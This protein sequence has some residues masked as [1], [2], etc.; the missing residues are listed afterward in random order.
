MSVPI[1]QPGV[2]TV[3]DDPAKPWKAL[4]GAFAAGLLVVIRQYFLGSNDI[5][6]PGLLTA[7]LT[8]A[9]T[10][11]VTYMT[12]NPKVVATNRNGL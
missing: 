8:F 7:I 6:W 10:F 4:L 9:V 1:D 2:P 11:G 3:K 12:K 5:G